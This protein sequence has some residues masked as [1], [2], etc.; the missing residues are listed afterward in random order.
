MSSGTLRRRLVAAAALA[1]F[2]AVSVLGVT[3]ALLVGR[4]L[5][6]SL[7][8]GLHAR[9]VDVARLAVSAPA[10]L[11]APGALDAPQGGRELAVEVV[12]RHGRIVA[13][14][15][16]LGGRLLPGGTLLGSAIAQGTAGYRDGQLSQERVRV[17]PCPSPTPAG[18]PAAGR[19]WCHPR[20]ATSSRPWAEYAG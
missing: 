9:A 10:L 15:A 7:D 8:A 19:C 20:S 2:L 3:V 11:T 17:T 4:Q 12:D 1:I 13:R 5:R 16:G 18:P 6:S 14:S